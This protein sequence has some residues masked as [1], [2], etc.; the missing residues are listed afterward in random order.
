MC[1]IDKAMFE[2]M[3]TIK[4]DKF[5]WENRWKPKRVHLKNTKNISLI[6]HFK[7][8]FVLKA[9][10]RTIRSVCTKRNRFEQSTLAKQRFP[11]ME[12]TDTNAMR[13]TKTINECD[14]SSMT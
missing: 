1:E 3:N 10:H 5:Q 13:K 6:N 14:R 8:L 11:M 2:K 7:N 12:I 9:R 4:S